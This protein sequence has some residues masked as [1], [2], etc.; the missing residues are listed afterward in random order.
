M[1]VLLDYFGAVVALVEF[2]AAGAV[3]V[4][5]LRIGEVSPAL[6]SERVKRAVAEQAV[7]LVGVDALV[8]GEVLALPVREK[9]VLVCVARFHAVIIT[10]F[11]GAGDAA[12]WHDVARGAVGIGSFWHDTHGPTCHKAYTAKPS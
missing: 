8:A 10:G 9:G 2:R 12:K 4:A 1:K 5:L 11:R 7:E 3:F 6:G